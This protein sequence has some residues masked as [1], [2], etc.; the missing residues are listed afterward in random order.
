MDPYQKEMLKS[1]LQ[2]FGKCDVTVHGESMKPFIGSGDTV[3]LSPYRDAPRLGEVIAFFNDNQLLVHRIIWRKKVALGEWDF[4]AWGDSSP[5]KP[6]RVS[7]R[8]C[9]GRVTGIT[10]NARSRNLW[11]LFPF[12]IF[13]LIA[14]IFLHALYLLKR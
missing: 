6:G 3:S 1:A 9:I 13:A 8:E 7:S 14:G 2:S 10:R 12:R 11:I 4:W 5:G